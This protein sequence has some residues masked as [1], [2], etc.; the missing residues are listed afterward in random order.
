[1]GLQKQMKA[2]LVACLATGLVACSSM[3]KHGQPGSDVN[4]ANAAYGAQSSGLGEEAGYNDQA[5][6][7][8]H[9]ISKNTYYFDFDSNVIHNQD[10]P[11]IIANANYLLTHPHAKITIEGHTD[12]RGS[13]EYNVGLGDRRAQAVAHMM[14]AKGV[15]PTQIRVVS[16]G[17]QKLASPGRTEE[18]YRLDRRAVVVYLQK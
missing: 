9:S 16:Y 6:L 10:K 15:N 13:R 2:I 18:A 14:L 11:S 1:M 3:H 8:G 4:A 7:N 17:A 5:G 12:P